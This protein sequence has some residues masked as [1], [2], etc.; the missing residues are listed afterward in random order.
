MQFPLHFSLFQEPSFRSKFG[1]ARRGGASESDVTSHGTLFV[2]P[3]AH[4]D[5]ED[6]AVDDSGQPKASKWNAP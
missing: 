1:R 4:Q 3:V 6:A 5:K 2:I